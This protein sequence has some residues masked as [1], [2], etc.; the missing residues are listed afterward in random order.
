MEKK[1]K[2]P[3]SLVLEQ[4]YSDV[5]ELHSIEQQ[6]GSELSYCFTLLIER[7][8]KKKNTLL[9][10]KLKNIHKKLSLWMID[11]TAATCGCSK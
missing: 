11:G 3:I 1:K 8:K 4:K 7:E 2:T 6:W 9:L 5:T 10:S